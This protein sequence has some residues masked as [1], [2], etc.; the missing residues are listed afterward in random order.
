MKNNY[1]PHFLLQI[2]D[3]HTF[4][5]EQFFKTTE[6]AILKDYVNS[7]FLGP[8]CFVLRYA[9]DYGANYDTFGIVPNAEKMQTPEGSNQ[10]AIN[11]KKMLNNLLP[12]PLAI[13]FVSEGK[14]NEKD[15]F[16]LIS[17]ETPFSGTKKLFRVYK[18][19]TDRSYK[20]FVYDS[21]ASNDVVSYSIEQYCHLLRINPLCLNFDYSN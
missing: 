2:V 10:E 17:F 4:A 21:K 7:E 14:I 3:Q 15:C 6:H 12:S 19:E 1:N 9:S 20:S 11:L 16:L 18:K 13:V 8:R 5:I